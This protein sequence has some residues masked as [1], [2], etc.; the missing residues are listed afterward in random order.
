LYGQN[1]LHYIASDLH[2]KGLYQN[3]SYG[4][5]RFSGTTGWIRA[6][7]NSFSR[8]EIAL[9]FVDTTFA[10]TWISLLWRVQQAIGP[11]FQQRFAPI[12]SL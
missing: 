1:N 12:W 7:S 11:G 8:T 2:K 9:S 5:V 6:A 4:F 3:F 10:R